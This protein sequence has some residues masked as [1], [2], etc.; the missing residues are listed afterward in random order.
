MGRPP[1]PRLRRPRCPAPPPPPS[2]PPVA[3]VHVPALKPKPF[4]QDEA[5]VPIESLPAWA[6]PAFKGMKSLNRVQSRVYETC[7]FSPENML[8][9][10]PTGAGKTNV[11]ML[12][13]LH[14]IGV[15]RD[16]ATGE[17]D[18][19]AF[20][21][22][23][24]APMK[25][26]VQEMVLN[27]RKRLEPFGVVVNELTGDQQLT[28]EQ[29]ANTQ[30]IVTTPEKWDIIT[31]KSGDRTYTQ[32]VRLVIIDEIHLLHDHR[33]P[34]LESIVARTIRQIETTQEMIRVVGLSATLPNYADVATFLRVNPDK[35]L[36]YF[37]NSF[38]PVPLQQQ[39]IGI[40]EK[41]AIK[42]FQL[43]NEIVYE[44]VLSQAG[45]NQVLVFVHS[46]KECAKT[47]RA[48]RDMALE[49][50][51]LG[52]FLQE[53]GASREILQTEAETCK[54][55]DVADLLPYGFAVH[56]AGMTRAD[57]TLVEDLFADGHIQVLVSTATLAWGVNLP[58][59]TVIIKGTQVYS[60]EK[61]TWGELSMMDVMQMLGR[62]G[63]PQ[64]MGRAD[65]Q[66]EGI[67]IT[68]HSELQYYLSLLNQQLPI[69][70]QY[71][72]KLADNLNAEIV[73][74]TVQN[75]REAVNWIGYT[76]LYVRMLRN[77]SL[78]G[79]S[80]G[81]LS[82]DPLLE[83]RRTD[84][85]HTAATTLDKCA[86]I[87]YERK[88]GQFQVTDL[89]RV[90]A[91]YYVSHSTVAVYNDFLKPTLSDI[92]V[93]RLFAL[94]KDFANISVREE[95][96]GEL[97]RLIDRVPIPIKETVDEP[98]AKVNV[99]LQAYVSNLKLD[100]FSLLSDMVYVTQ[101]AA[102]LMRCLHEIVLKR[103]WAA[104]ADRVLNFCKMID[105]RMWLCQT[106]LRQFHGI[107]EDII[108]KI[109]KKDFPWER[110]YDLQPQEIGERVRFPKMGKMIHR[111]V[112]QFPR[113]EL[114]AHV[115]PITRTV[116]RVEL[117]I[118]PDFAFEP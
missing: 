62:A 15:H 111:F 68:T 98:S 7:L 42:R 86:L 100:G 88:S 84:L 80:E 110:F 106:P 18:L 29:I 107:P 50:D 118:T 45:K 40:T 43:M 87:K 101:S 70:S 75:A 96:K 11:A 6:Q 21:I 48:I 89:G 52:E 26:L 91:Y 23:Y 32:L 14:E 37:D 1:P 117:T 25:A 4:E 28:K 9:C 94:S 79:A 44:K 109:E 77:P 56:H 47:A 63:R 59:H 90:A 16:K 36:F 38:R 39:Y 95:E 2:P 41:K 27:F 5:L 74:G 35:G 93:L 82:T 10:A 53:D 85:I 55:K 67:I 81:E 104:L 12:S 116:L 66:G 99:L 72:G 115:Q 19:D 17:I 31:R 33:G 92:E 46:R 108:K 69:E 3:Q 51:T 20:K 34:V 30:M 78:Y 73:L 8:L 114:A 64:F 112:H 105:R 71:I 22:V 54:N 65:E 103:G 24:V 83:Q 113:L 61:G 13:I 76:Y 60:P 49:R 97:A 102:R 57:R 58:A